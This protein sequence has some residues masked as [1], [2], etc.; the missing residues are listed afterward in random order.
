MS[1]FLIAVGGSGAKLMH[2]LIHLGAAGMLPADRSALTALLV[3]PDENNGNIEEC[4]SLEKIYQA[5]KLLKV[6]KTDLFRG[7]ISLAGP[8]SP[9]FKSQSDSLEEIFN[10]N[11][12]ANNRSEEADLMELFFE[13][14]EL[15][16]SVKQGF[17]GRP[18]IGATVFANSVKF[19]R[20]VWKELRESI[21]NTGGANPHILFAGSVFGG[22]GASGVPTLLRLLSNHIKADVKDARYGLILFLPFFKFRQVEGEAI[23]ADPASFPTATAEALKYYHERGFLSICN[24]LYA[25]GEEVL[26][27]MSVSA[28]GAKEQRNEPHFIELVA[29][30]G[31]LRFFDKTDT[32]TGD[33][34]LAVT[35][36]AEDGKLTWDDLPC[37]AGLS[38]ADVRHL[39]N[40]LQK[41]AVFAVAYHYIF[42]PEIL[43]A[44]KSGGSKT[45]YWKEHVER[46]GVK[47]DEARGALA[48][49][50]SYTVKVLEW[51]LHISTP[52]RPNFLPGM[53]NPNV[54]G[55]AQGQEWRLKIPRQ[56]NQ[57][58]LGG[59]L[60]NRP[61]AKIDDRTVLRNA[62]GSTVKDPDA[63][64]PG[65]LVRALF[66]ACEV[67]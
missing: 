37:D 2:T 44:L 23:Q 11:Q 66:D 5:C 36:R 29:G 53:V 55:V 3:D 16:M 58:D 20:G 4:Q 24:T 1:N 9:I 41:L 25:L 18:S 39:Q 65:R 33:N 45:P 7:E 27:E 21:K 28:V 19:D 49:V 8:W 10:Y 62:S 47:P 46:K 51:L 43:E 30:M 26:T 14:A 67:G 60:L 40:K 6:G 38:K 64:G 50:D 57:T 34:S 63:V 61:K 15:E 12:L 42:Y 35:A 13:R 17:R 32:H 54:F 48:A 59:L 52:R 22:S 56:F 31:A